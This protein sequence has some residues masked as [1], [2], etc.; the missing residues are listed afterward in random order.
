MG[1]FWHRRTGGSRS[2]TFR[3]YC[4]AVFF[5]SSGRCARL[6]LLRFFTCIDRPGVRSLSVDPA[7]ENV[8]D[9]HEVLSELLVGCEYVSVKN[10][11]A[12]PL[13]DPFDERDAEPCQSIFVGHHNL[14]DSSALELF[15]K[16]RVAF[17]LV[18]AVG[19]ISIVQRLDLAQEV[20]EMLAGGDGG[21]L[22]RLR[23]PPRPCV[24]DILAIGL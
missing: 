18:D 6:S 16:P 19:G 2:L 24:V 21:G 17:P 12:C 9:C 23:P 8:Y 4:K 15:Q 10:D 20:V 1:T 14:F 22:D 5:S 11:E 13:D 3:W 7:R